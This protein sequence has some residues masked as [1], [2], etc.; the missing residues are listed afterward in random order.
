MPG[1]LKFVRI[2]AI[3]FGVCLVVIDVV[4][5]FSS[6]PVRK[7]EIALVLLSGAVILMPQGR[8]MKTRFAPVFLALNIIQAVTF[9]LGF[10]W[11]L[12]LVLVEHKHLPGIWFLAGCWLILCGNAECARRAYLKVL[13]TPNRSPQSVR[14]LDPLS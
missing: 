14:T 3:V 4:V 7:W 9:T 5:F 12:W 11:R 6:A 13:E 10:G 8:I 1:L 2:V